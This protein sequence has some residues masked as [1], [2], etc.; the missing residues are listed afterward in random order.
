MH[1]SAA[2]LSALRRDKPLSRL[3]QVGQFLATFRIPYH[4]SDRNGN[5]QVLAIA[6]VAIRA[7]AVL[8]ARGSIVFLVAKI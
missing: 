1:I 3:D 2:P 5:D 6:P 8:T 7:H 4:G